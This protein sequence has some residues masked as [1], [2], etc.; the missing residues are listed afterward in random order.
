LKSIDYKSEQA[1]AL[2]HHLRTILAEGKELLE[3][4]AQ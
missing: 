4:L 3:Q 2:S 1:I